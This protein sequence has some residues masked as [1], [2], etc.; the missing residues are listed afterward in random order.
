MAPYSTQRLGITVSEVRIIPVEY[1]E[2]IDS[3]PRTTMT[4]WPSRASPRTLDWVGSKPAR[5]C[6]A[7]CDQWAASP[8]QNATLQATLAQQDQQLQ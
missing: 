1:S 3:T 5:S 2:V 6:A 4:S 7:M 8:A